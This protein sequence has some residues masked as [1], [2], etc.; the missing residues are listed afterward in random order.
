MMKRRQF[1]IGAVTAGLVTNIH[2][3]LAA[4]KPEYQEQTIALWPDIPPGGGGPRGKLFISPKGNVSNIAIPTLTILTPPQPNGHGVLIAGGG[5]YR[6][7][8]IGLE[9]RPAAELLVARGYTAYILTYRLPGEG[10]KD[11][12]LV[13]LQDAQRALRIMQQ[14]EKKVSVLGFSAGGHLMGMAALRPHFESYPPQ[15]ALDETPIIVDKAALIY[16]IITLEKPYTHTST[17]NVLVGKNASNEEDMA[18][19]VQTYVTPD[20]PPFFLVQADNDPI[21]KLQNILIMEKACQENHVPVT[22][23]RYPIGGHGFALGKPN[24]P[25]AAWPG[26]YEEWLKNT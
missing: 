11:G 10:W 3:A 15:D 22:L 9:S 18:W 23:Y 6:N 25:A 17:H 8:A 4:A 24:T 21:A 7:I 5:G 14:Y 26:H 1:I 20:S 2:E 19:S 12:S 13:P 16:P